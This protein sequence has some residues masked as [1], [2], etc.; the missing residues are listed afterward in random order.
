MAIKPTHFIKLSLALL[1]LA[2]AIGC[3]SDTS[4][5][6]PAYADSTEVA[7][8]ATAEDTIVRVIDILP[9]DFVNLQEA[10]PEIVFDLKYGTA[11]NF[12]GR[13][14]PGYEKPVPYAIAELAE[15]LGMVQ[16]DLRKSGLGL[17]VFDAYRPQRS[18]NSF[19]EWAKD[20]QDQLVKNE[21][22]PEIDKATLFERGFIASRSKHSRGVA[23]DLTL[24][25]WDT[26]EEVDMGT[27]FDFF[28]ELSAHG[29]SG[30]TQQQT[31]NRNQLKNV[32][33]KYGFEPYSKEWWH[34]SVPTDQFENVYFDYPL[35]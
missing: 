23:I 35:N 6:T 3:A 20:P 15:R 28:G 9:P 1:V 16:Q 7:G 5:D 31:A 22:Y 17:K 26:K 29:A 25:I 21:F 12:T 8:T 2:G 13:P 30:L 19:I 32:M 4:R 18:V 24:I 33:I 34:Y 10:F 14:V 27:P 11:D